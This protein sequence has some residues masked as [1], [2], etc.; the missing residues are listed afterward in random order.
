MNWEN[1]FTLFRSRKAGQR[2]WAPK[3]KDEWEE[4]G[5]RVATLLPRRFGTGSAYTYRRTWGAAYGWSFSIYTTA[6]GDPSN[7]KGFGSLFSPSSLLG[8]YGINR[9]MG[10]LQLLRRAMGY[11]GYGHPKEDKI[12][13][14]W[15]RN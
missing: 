8:W 4:M 14:F 15:F 10:V 3:I 6:V 1:L 12:R 2:Q 9:S 13:V 11:V 5:Q 7:W